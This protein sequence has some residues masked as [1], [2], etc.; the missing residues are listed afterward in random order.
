MGAPMNG[1]ISEQHSDWGKAY[2]TS[3]RFLN[4]I[5]FF[6]RLQFK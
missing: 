1:T 5:P 4:H 6:L 2:Y 3:F